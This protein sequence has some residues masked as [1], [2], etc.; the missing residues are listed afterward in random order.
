MPDVCADQVAVGM[1]ELTH[2][3]RPLPMPGWE[4]RKH[5][6]G[7]D[8]P[9]DRDREHS[10]STDTNAVPRIGRPPIATGKRRQRAHVPQHVDCHRAEPDDEADL[11]DA[12]N[13]R[14]WPNDGQH[15]AG[16]EEQDRFAAN[17]LLTAEREYTGER[18][19]R[20]RYQPLLEG[21]GVKTEWI[22]FEQLAGGNGGP[23]CSSQVINRGAPA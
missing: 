18:Q 23:H 9:T 14:V 4:L 22:E 2:H 10:Y 16:R 19:T 5:H 13:R 15:D 3:Q 11:V 8:D 12:V 20:D 7:E 17:G 1:M 21:C 6:C